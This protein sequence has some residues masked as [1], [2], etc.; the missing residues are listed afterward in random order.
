MIFCTFGDVKK[1]DKDKIIHELRREIEVKDET[2]QKLLRKIYR[3]NN[4]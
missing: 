3:L 1:E 4:G 2:I